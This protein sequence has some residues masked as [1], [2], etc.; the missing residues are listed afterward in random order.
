MLEKLTIKEVLANGACPSI[1]FDNFSYTLLVTIGNKKRAP[2]G[3][4]PFHN[5]EN[6]F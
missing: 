2:S 6:T 4:T 1:C 5:G 3:G